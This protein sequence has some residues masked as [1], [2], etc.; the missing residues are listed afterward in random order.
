MSLA[1]AAHVIGSRVAR[2]S[3]AVRISRQRDVWPQLSLLDAVARPR[4]IGS[5]A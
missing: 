3:A 5:Q 4:S 1:T 2:S